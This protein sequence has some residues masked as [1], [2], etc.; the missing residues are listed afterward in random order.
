MLTNLTRS[1]RL[2]VTKDE[3]YFITSKCAY[4][5]LAKTLMDSGLAN[6]WKGKVTPFTSIFCG[7]T[8]G[9]IREIAESSEISTLRSMP[10]CSRIHVSVAP[11]YLGISNSGLAAHNIRAITIPHCRALLGIER[12]GS[13]NNGI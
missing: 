7:L 8:D 4:L 2:P 3:S 6:G 1:S 12:K 10:S 13:N 5:A 11:W 9:F